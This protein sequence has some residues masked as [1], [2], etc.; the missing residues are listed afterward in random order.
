MHGHAVAYHAI[1]ALQPKAQVGF[2]KHMIWWKPRFLLSPVDHIAFQVLR[3]NFNTITLDLI[4][5][6]DWRP[7]PFFGK[8]GHFPEFKGTLDWMGIN[9]YHRYDVGLNLASLFNNEP[10]NLLF[11][12]RHGL[13]KGPEWWGELW[14][15]GLYFLLK[16]LHD[17]FNLPLYIT[18]NGVPDPSDAHRPHFILDHLRRVWQAI[19]SGMDVRGYFHWSLVDNFEWLEA[20]NPAFYFG[21]YHVDFETQ[22]RTP[23]TSARLYGDIARSNSI[24]SRMAREYAP[25]S[26]PGLLPERSSLMQVA[27]HTLIPGEYEAMYHDHEHHRIGEHDHEVG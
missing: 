12:G 8:R 19:R 20:Y 15:D 16:N 5:H 2:A 14:P 1:H 25:E 23:R 24:S 22:K 4:Q 26:L 17:R 6:G 3:H 7:L 9:Y 10:Y 21:L 27:G 13:E 11:M 18:E